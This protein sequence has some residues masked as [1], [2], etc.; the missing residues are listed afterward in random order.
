M[1]VV[2]DKEDNL[3]QGHQLTVF[4]RSEEADYSPNTTHH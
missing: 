2:E 4:N 3:K 1:R